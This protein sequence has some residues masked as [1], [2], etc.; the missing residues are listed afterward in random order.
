TLSPAIAPWRDALRPQ[1]ASVRAALRAIAHALGL[2]PPEVMQSL[3]ASLDPGLALRKF[4]RFAT[5]EG[6]DARLFT[7]VEDWLNDPVPVAP[8]VAEEVLADWHL[9]AALTRGWQLMGGPVRPDAI[10]CPTLSFCATRDTIAPPTNAEALPRAIPGARILRPD[11]GHV[12]MIVGADAARAVHL[13]LRK[14]L[15]TL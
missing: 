15:E 7:A 1:G 12:G 9:D 10:A 2:I 5:L 6:F 4:E 11:S 3:F 14:F 8:R 13:P